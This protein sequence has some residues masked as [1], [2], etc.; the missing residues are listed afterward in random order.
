M[1]LPRVIR[2]ASAEIEDYNRV[3]VMP[4]ADVQVVGHAV[5]TWSTCWPS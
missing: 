2:A 1:P 5:S 4:M 3:G